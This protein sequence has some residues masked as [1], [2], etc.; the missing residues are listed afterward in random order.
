MPQARK[1]IFEE[2]VDVI[3]AIIRADTYISG[4]LK[5]L[6]SGVTLPTADTPILP[7]G[8]TAI[9]RLQAPHYPYVS[10][11]TEGIDYPYDEDMNKESYRPKIYYDISFREANIAVAEKKCFRLNE[12]I[13]ET[14]EKGYKNLSKTLIT[15]SGGKK[16]GQVQRI[17]IKSCKLINF[18]KTTNTA[19]T[20]TEVFIN[21]YS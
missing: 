17:E 6:S 15:G 2:V 16:I 11:Y 1:Y 20:S 19:L 5:V 3:T 10:V 21:T 9:W 12:D 14:I 13:R 4:V 18:G 7:I 8:E